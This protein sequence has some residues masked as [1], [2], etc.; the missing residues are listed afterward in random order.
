MQWLTTSEAEG[1]QL[2]IVWIQV[3]LEKLESAADQERHGHQRGLAQSTVKPTVDRER[4]DQLNAS[5]KG[6]FYER[7]SKVEVVLR[8]LLKRPKALQY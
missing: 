2:S 7:S 4:P 8:N 6:G 3:K 1:K 5:D